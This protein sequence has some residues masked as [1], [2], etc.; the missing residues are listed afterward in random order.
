MIDLENEEVLLTVEEVQEFHQLEGLSPPHEYTPS[1]EDSQSSESHET[2]S[3]SQSVFTP[4]DLSELSSSEEEDNA[5][6]SN[7][8][9]GKRYSL[10][11]TTV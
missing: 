10:P 5:V 9:G 8:S 2:D 11:T 3:P 6:R 7:R 4:S 1:R